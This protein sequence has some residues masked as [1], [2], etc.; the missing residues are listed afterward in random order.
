MVLLLEWLYPSEVGFGAHHPGADGFEMAEAPLQLLGHGMNIAEAAL[1]RM[2]LEDRS[3]AGCVVSEV[4]RLARFVNRMR[5]SH[6]HGHALRHRDDRTGAEMLPDLRHRLQHE[7]PCRTQAD[8][9]LG[10]IGLHDGVVPDRALA[11]TRHLGFCK[12]DEAIER[13]AGDAASYTRKADLIAGAVAHAI[14]RAVLAAF[15][16][17]LADDGV[18]GSHEEVV[19]RELVARG[20]AQA[21][22]VPDVGPFDILATHQHGALGLLAIVVEPRGAVGLEDRTV[23]AKPGGVT[24]PGRK[25]PDAGDAIAAFALDGADFGSRTPGQHRAGIVAEDR[26]SEEHTS[27]L[28]S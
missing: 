19:E 11:A 3:R 8:L 4:D 10:E 2:A 23:R 12:I 16:P 14:E 27:E 22:R 6:A 13:A 17:E 18:I 28:Q 25:R 26:R 15:A 7:A 20:A 5:C 24:A 9:G 21:H 1:Q